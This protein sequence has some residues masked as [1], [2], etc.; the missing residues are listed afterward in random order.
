MRYLCILRVESKKYQQNTCAFLGAVPIN[1]SSRFVSELELVKQPVIFATLFR[2]EDECAW[3]QKVYAWTK[4]LDGWEFH[5]TIFVSAHLTKEAAE[6]HAPEESKRIRYALHEID[7]RPSLFPTKNISVEHDYFTHGNFSG[8]N[9]E[10]VLGTPT[11]QESGAI[12]LGQP[13]VCLDHLKFFE[14]LSEFGTEVCFVRTA[15]TTTWTSAVINS[16][17]GAVS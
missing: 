14:R 5:D 12:Q 6:Q 17:C 9:S 15:H 2:I 1:H 10:W 16:S 11:S 13:R 4:H 3:P 8:T 7:V